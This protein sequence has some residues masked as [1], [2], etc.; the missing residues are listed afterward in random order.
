MHRRVFR[1]RN[2]EVR[3]R[4]RTKLEKKRSQGRYNKRAHASESPFGN[5]KW[6]LKFYAV[7]R[8]GIGKVRMEAALLF[9]LHN[10]MKMAPALG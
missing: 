3:D 5:F 6:N 10:F 9:M 4:M 2:E 7:M 8:R 1:D